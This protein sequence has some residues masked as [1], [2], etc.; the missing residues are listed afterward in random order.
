MSHELLFSKVKLKIN[1]FIDDLKSTDSLW[2]EVRFDAHVD[3]ISDCRT[4]IK[5]LITNFLEKTNKNPGQ[6]LTAQGNFATSILGILND[7]F[8]IAI[9]T[10]D[11]LINNFRVQIS[12][13]NSVKQELTRKR[14]R[15]GNAKPTIDKFQTILYWTN[16]IRTNMSIIGAIIYP[17]QRT[18]VKV[19]AKTLNSQFSA[20]Q[21]NREILEQ[22]HDKF[23]EFLNND[24]RVPPELFESFSRFQLNLAEL[25]NNA[26]FIA[27]CTHLSK[28][29]EENNE[30]MILYYG[31]KVRALNQYFAK[32]TGDTEEELHQIVLE[33]VQE[34]T[35]FLQVP[36]NPT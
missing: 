3:K 36:S 1:Q 20:M 15:V 25:M 6:F 9:V 32:V 17:M 31:K 33:N 11:S 30:E 34:P 26:D 23:K 8:M 29:V 4:S 12:S 5:E 10:K 22:C 13:L 2:N 27:V 24:A 16:A 35:S 7:R 18:V 14:E 28:A 21:K 19:N